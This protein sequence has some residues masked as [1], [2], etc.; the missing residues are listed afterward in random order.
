[1]SEPPVATTARRVADRALSWL[2]AHRELGAVPADS[3]EDLGDPDTVYKPLGETTLA[4][5]LILRDATAGAGQQVAA[6]SLADYTWRQLGEG[7]LLYER[8]LRHTLMTDP[9]ENYA[10]FARVGYRH[11]RLDRLLEH[12]AGLRSIRAI[13]MIPNRRMAVANAA[14]IVG[15]DHGVDWAALVRA[16]WLGHTPE[17]WAID[18]MTAYHLTHA[19]FHA[20]DWGARPD[21]L[22][23]DVTAYLRDWLPVWIDVW[24]EIQQWDLMT[25]LLIVGAC[26]PEPYCD[27]ADWRALA[28]IQ[29]D[30]GFV[31]RDGEPVTGDPA[32]RF[33]DHQH[34]VVVTAVAGSI[35]ASRAAGRPVEGG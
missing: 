13:E 27:A 26:L 24:R 25:E 28:E 30:D 20:T 11:P 4:A 35:A 34:T 31:P 2:H 5:S 6:Q 1:M 12:H 10:H 22:P 16:S 32:E 17:P 7:D 15:L 23:A 29:H 19:V 33:R 8:Q 9:L 18:W 3:T 21:G 14:R